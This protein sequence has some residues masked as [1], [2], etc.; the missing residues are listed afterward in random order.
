MSLWQVDVP[1]HHS[2]PVA[3]FVEN[4]DW[5]KLTDATKFDVILMDPPWDLSSSDPMRGVTISYGTLGT[6]R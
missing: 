3:G 6:S 4:M 2:V 1:P 5:K